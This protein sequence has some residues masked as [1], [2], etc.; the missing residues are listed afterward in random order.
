MKAEFWRNHFIK[1]YNRLS[2]RRKDGILEAEMWKT[3]SPIGT[4][5][6]TFQEAREGISVEAEDLLTHKIRLQKRTFTELEEMFDY[7]E[8]FWERL[9][10]LCSAE[11]LKKVDEYFHEK[12]RL[13]LAKALAE[14]LEK[15][16]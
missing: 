6:L 3:I 5:V 12:R 16:C 1:S 11:P 8:D 13:Y 15:S 9:A 14:L 7:V 10:D 2:F 4:I